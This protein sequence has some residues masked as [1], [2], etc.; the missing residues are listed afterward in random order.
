MALICIVAD[1]PDPVHSMRLYSSQELECV[2]ETH[3]LIS[4]SENTS[5][6]ARSGLLRSLVT[7][8]YIVRA[9]N[10][11]HCCCNVAEKRIE[12]MRLY[13]VHSS[14]SDITKN[15]ASLPNEFLPKQFDEFDEW[16]ATNVRWTRHPA[17][18]SAAY[19]GDATLR[20]HVEIRSLVKRYSESTSPTTATADTADK[21]QFTPPLTRVSP[22]GIVRTICEEDIL[23]TLPA[24]RDLDDILKRARALARKLEEDISDA[25]SLSTM[26]DLDTK[27]S[28]DIDLA[29]DDY[30]VEWDDIPPNLDVQ[31]ALFLPFRAAEELCSSCLPRGKTVPF[32]ELVNCTAGNLHDQIL[33]SSKESPAKAWTRD[34]TTNNTNDYVVVRANLRKVGE[35]K[36]LPTAESVVKSDCPS[37]GL[38][39]WSQIETTPQAR[40]SP[41]RIVPE[42]QD[43][44][45]HPHDAK[46]SPTS[47]LELG[48]AL[49]LLRP[50]NQSPRLGQYVF[51]SSATSSTPDASNLTSRRKNAV[52]NSWF[53]DDSRKI[54]FPSPADPGG[55]QMGRAQSP[56]KGI[57]QVS[58]HDEPK[59]T[60][61]SSTLDTGVQHHR[62]ENR[63]QADRC[64]PQSLYGEMPA[65][66]L[67][68]NP[69]DD[70][71]Y[72]KYVRMIKMGLPMGAVKN[73]TTMDGFDPSVLDGDTT[74]TVPTQTLKSDTVRRFRIRWE[75][76]NNAGS[77][78]VWTMAKDDPA[79]NIQL[80]EVEVERLFRSDLSS[81]PPLLTTRDHEQATVKVIDPKRA[82]NGGIALARIQISYSDIA[83]AIDHL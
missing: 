43:H 44:D 32:R 74:N 33:K 18:S 23:D 11:S 30:L 51:R 26:S 48:R 61:Y 82:N 17:Q 3:N 66:Q 52:D 38:V 58:I 37:R 6:H 19:E 29:S 70:S 35:Y 78:T 2:H 15:K 54:L 42:K 67:V 36:T 56:L 62:V 21:T 16:K 71:K 27:D 53:P 4:R 34:H 57:A 31:D 40:Q 68:L 69:H 72:S 64:D 76:I 41:L 73:A 8:G 46:N 14:G 13:N 47:A 55:W 77:K 24:L 28:F 7:W 1:R 5:H 49:S 10:S 45:Y 81:H 39:E 75:A 59:P 79:V 50:M 22:D 83:R 80:D 65:A 20:R 9:R 63:M 60:K 25:S 12:G